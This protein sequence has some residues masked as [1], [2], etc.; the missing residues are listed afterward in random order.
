MEVNNSESATP[1][2]IATIPTSFETNLGGAYRVGR[3]IGCGSFGE[4]YLGTSL[5]T[6]KEVAI[7]MEYSKKKN[8]HLLFEARIYKILGCRQGIPRVFWYGVKG[9]YNVM[10]M[11]L[12]GPSLE[13][14]FSYCGRKFQLKTVLMLAD[15]MIKRIETVHT[16]GF[17]HRDIKPHN[18][19]IGR[20]SNQSTIYIIDFGLA[21]RFRNPISHQHIPYR[22]GKSLTGTARYVSVGTHLGI[23]QSRRDDMESLGY[24]FVYFI[25][26]SLPWQ[27][28]KAKSKRDKY[29]KIRDKKLTTS[30]ERLCH[31]IAWEFQAYLYYC[32]RL[33]FTERPDYDHLRNLF[34]DLL[35]SE[36]FSNDNIF[37]WVGLLSNGDPTMTSQTQQLDEKEEEES[38]EV[39]LSDVSVHVKPGQKCKEYDHQCMS[40]ICEKESNKL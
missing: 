17:I 10:I 22:E 8:P 27:G 19:L 3:K 25:H 30:I 36:G 23:E 38:G 28:L 15:Q 26:G 1:P 32:R 5:Q 18:F 9:G 40:G 21:K 20:E 24:V 16:L 2:P 12:L 29:E 11:E 39:S 14:L 37:D 13:D 35:L 33:S 31:F 4:I 7:K 34:K 6:G